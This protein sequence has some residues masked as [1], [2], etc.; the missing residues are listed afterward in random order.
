MTANNE[1]NLSL[2]NFLNWKSQ[3]V[4]SYVLSEQI[5]IFIHISVKCCNHMR[6][7]KISELEILWILLNMAA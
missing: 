4:S 1:N 5:C 7:I 6:P 2:W 3:N